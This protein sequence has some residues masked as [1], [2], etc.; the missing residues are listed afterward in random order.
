VSSNGGVAN[1]VT[2][3][4]DNCKPAGW[5]PDGKLVLYRQIGRTGTYRLTF[6]ER[7]G[8]LIGEMPA[9][10]ASSNGSGDIAFL[11]R[12]ITNYGLSY[13]SDPTYYLAYGDTDHGAIAFSSSDPVK[14]ITAAPVGNLVAFY[15]GGTNAGIYTR[16]LITQQESLLIPGS[17]NQSPSWGPYIPVRFLVGTQGTF[18][19]DAGGFLFGQQ[20]DWVR[21][22]VTFDATTRS[23]INVVKQTDSNPTQPN[24]V[25]VVTADALTT[26]KFRNDLSGSA[27]VVV[28]PANPQAGA[29]VSFNADTGKVSSVIPFKTLV[30][31]RS[32]SGVYTG[33][34][35]GIWN[36]EGKNI[37]SGGAK[38]IELDPATGAARILR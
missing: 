24:A 22:F 19:A 35:S 20:G 31:T 23:T 30:S 29:V 17:G 4:S 37:A 6:F 3:E 21:S 28:S 5:R 26:L 27:T 32:R 14:S 8:T 7:N 10:F 25:A 2:T 11:N 9:T 33:E 34:F 18:G 1:P 38:E 36:A 15:R 16:S 13:F 12:D